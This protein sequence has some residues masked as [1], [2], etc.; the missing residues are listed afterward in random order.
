MAVSEQQVLQALRE[1]QDPDLFKDIVTLNQVKNIKIC[2]G[3]IA[4]EVSTPSPLKDQLRKAIV[5]AVATLPGVEEVFVNFS[6]SVAAVPAARAGG[7]GGGG[8]HAHGHGGGGGAAGGGGG[9]PAPRGLPGVKHIVAVGAGKG[10]VGKSTVAVNLAL[11]LALS[12]KRVALLDGDIYGPSIPTLTGI[13]PQAPKIIGDRILPFTISANVQGKVVSLAVMSIGFMVDKEKALIWRGPMAHGAM[14]QMIEQVE[15]T[16]DDAGQDR[17]ELD[18]LIVDL[19]PGTGDVSL[20]LAQTVP[21]TGAVIVATPQEVALADARR[22]VRMFQQLGV[23]ILGVVEN[24]SYFVCDH[25]TEYDIFG[26]GGAQVMA[27]Q[28]GLPFLGDLPIDTFLRRNSDAGTP[29]DN[30]DEKSRSRTKLLAMA[31]LLDKHVAVRL[32]TRPA[33]KPL[34]LQIS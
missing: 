30:F 7:G 15:W 14:K 28:M 8:G 11:G 23:E 21:L 16:R 3:N 24:M 25:G 4:V 26:R 27:Q 20:T 12:G 10:G 19:P 22:A 17:G 2:E 5:A 29:F 1:V 31:D 18:Y 9:P 34:N 6:A 33:A 32:V 13:A